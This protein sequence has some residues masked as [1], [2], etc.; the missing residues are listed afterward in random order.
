MSW[1]GYNFIHARAIRGMDLYNF[2]IQQI[3][4]PQAILEQGAQDKFIKVVNIIE[5]IISSVDYKTN[6]EKQT[7]IKEYEKQIDQMV[8][9]LYDLSEDEIKIV[10]G[11]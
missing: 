10:E 11:E 6:I 5:S 4:I 1:Y 3:P 7:K 9:E 8:Y 2:Y